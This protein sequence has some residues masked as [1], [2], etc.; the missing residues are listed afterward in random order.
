M[1]IYDDYESPFNSRYASLEMRQIFSNNNK[2]KTWR[3]MWIALAKA[4]KELGLDIS[5]E[6]IEELIKE[7][8]KID[9]A[10]IEE[11]ERKVKHDVMAHV[12]GYGKVC[13]KAS[14]IIHLGATSAD[15]TDNSE[16]IIIYQALNLVKT[17]VINIIYKLKEFALKYKDTPTLGYTHLQA[18]QLTSVGKRATLYLQDLVMDYKM[19]EY[20]ISSYKLRGIKGATGT[21]ASFMTLF[22]NDE[23]KVKQLEKLV[24]KYMGFEHYFGVSGQTYTRKYD[25]VILSCLSMIAQSASKFATD[26]RLLQS[27]KEIEEPFE[28]TQIGS[29]AMAYKHNPIR[30]ERICSIARYIESLPVNAAVTASTNWLE[31]TLDDSANKRIV[32]SEAFLAVDTILNLY[33]NIV[34]D[35]RVNLNVIKRN[36]NDELPF[37]ASEAILMECVKK[38]LSRQEAHEKIRQ[39]TFITL[40][41]VK[42]EGLNNNLVE[43]IKDDS[44]FALIKD[45]IDGLLNTTNFIGRSASQVEEFIKNEVDPILESQQIDKSSYKFIK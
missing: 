1:N 20:I 41:R 34:A 13:P 44:Y 31:R 4:E 37:M 39:L 19:L 40:K 10:Q 2:Y 33:D 38:G 22:N 42:E 18:A 27:K 15:I 9:Y 5:D 45:E 23:E 25:Y 35:L 12:L 21:Q 16:L 24:M 26:L 36:V 8:D 43:L 29:S 30:S 6:Q 7:Q 32:I 28:D 3:K 17:K 14:S 11:I